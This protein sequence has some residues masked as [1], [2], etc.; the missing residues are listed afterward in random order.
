[1]RLPSRELQIFSLS[2]LD[3]LAMAC[4]VFVLLLVL[5]MPYYR[6]SFDAA[7]AT[8]AI[9]AATAATV[10]QVKD[11]EKELQLLRGRA[12]RAIA[13]MERLDG[14]TAKLL[15]KAQCCSLKLTICSL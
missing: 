7:A 11:T 14:E 9:R 3:V 8:E 15:A 12:E 5:M 2:A 10:A 6:R 13:E 1:M 4:G